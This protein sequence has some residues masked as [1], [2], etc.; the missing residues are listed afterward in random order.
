MK[1]L[2]PALG[3]G[4]LLGAGCVYR[5]RIR[6]PDWPP[7]TQEEILRMTRSGVGEQVIIAKIQSEGFIGSVSS[8]D[9]EYLK[10]QGVSDKV[11]EAMI[12]ARPRVTYEEPQVIYRYSPTG[13]WLYDP[14]YWPWWHPAWY[15]GYRHHWYY[16]KS[17]QHRP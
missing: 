8:V 14:W 16:G 15:W 17:W 9:V 4:C 1:L 13:W 3:F 2:M 12:S 7:V 6:G 11:I 10:Q 5:E